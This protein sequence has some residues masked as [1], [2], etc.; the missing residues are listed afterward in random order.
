MLLR[1]GEDVKSGDLAFRAGDAPGATGSGGGA[2]AAWPFGAV[3]AVCVVGADIVRGRARRAFVDWHKNFL[4]RSSAPFRG[5]KNAA[6]ALAL[7]RR[8]S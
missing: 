8:A 1:Y 7:L 2:A 3:G 4:E 6:H 5:L